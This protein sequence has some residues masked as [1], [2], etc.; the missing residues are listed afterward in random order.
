M[1]LFQIIGY[2]NSGKT[3]LA[4][5]LAEELKKRGL[6]VGYIKHDP[7][8]KGVTDKKGS[9]TFRVKSFTEKTALVS[10]SHLTMWFMKEFTLKEVLKF[11]EDCDVV[12]VEGFKS[13]KGFPKILVGNLENDALKGEIV[14]TIKDKKDFPTALEWILENS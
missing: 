4:T 6:K 13:E 5:Y 12:L 9:D 7:K 1:R 8:G 2:H 14:L 11:F 10:P 3:T